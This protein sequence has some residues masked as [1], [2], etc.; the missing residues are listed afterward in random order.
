MASTHPAG[1]GECYR[2]DAMLNNTDAAVERMLAA[3]AR[4]MPG[5]RK[6]RAVRDLTNTAR[7]LQWAEL[8]SRCPA[9]PVEELR[10]RLLSR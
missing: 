7:R 8:R 9:A 4:E 2:H 6:L 3:A 1:A 10:L 5:W